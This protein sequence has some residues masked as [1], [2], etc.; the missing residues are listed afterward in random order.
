MLPLPPVK[1]P[2]H[3]DISG[4][5]RENLL[6]DPNLDPA[7][8]QSYVETLDRK[9]QRLKRSWLVGNVLVYPFNLRRVNKGALHANG[10]IA[11]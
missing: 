6:R 4:P 10:L 9:S 2:A 5:A 7:T 1:N 11:V 8:R 3:Q